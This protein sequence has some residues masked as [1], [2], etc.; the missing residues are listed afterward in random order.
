M[1]FNFTHNYLFETR[2]K[3]NIE[4]LD[5]VTETK[6][7]G[8]IST[9]DLKWDQNTNIIVKRSYSRME[10]LGTLSGFDAPQKDLKL[11][12]IKCIRSVHEQSSRVWH[13]GL[14]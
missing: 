7:I 13:S 8:T 1:H 11:V 9:N 5:T 6:L 2:L 12:Y 3:S 14:T 10:L 4:H